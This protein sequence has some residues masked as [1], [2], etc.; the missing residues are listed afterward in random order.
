MKPFVLLGLLLAVP[1]CASTRPSGGAA[2]AP[3]LGGAPERP[4]DPSSRWAPPPAISL[5]PPPEGDYRLAPKDQV[6]VQVHG[7]D[8][9]TRTVRISEGGTVPL[10]LLG[11]VKVPV[12]G[13]TL[14]EAEAKIKAGLKGR[15]LVNPRV[16]VS[17]VEFAG[18][19]VAVMGAVQQPGAYALKGNATTVLVALAEARGVRENADRVAYVVRARPRVGEP[20]PVVVD[21]GALLRTGDGRYNVALEGGDA[22]FVPE[23]SVYYVA[24][25]VEKRGAYPLRRGMTVSKALAEAGGVTK[26]AATGEIKIVRTLPSG[27]RREITGIDLEAVMSG[28]QSQDPPLETHDVVMVPASGAKVVAHGVL[29]F[30]RG[31]LSLGITP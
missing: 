18:R 4:A 7:H 21:L 17:V 10:P 27:E 30:F 29:D 31:I 12:A 5:E 20:Q 9:L 1:G 26:R 2:L 13:L 22:V 15:Y 14:A 8:D 24:G 6:V 19:K 11:D 28:D 25:E 16:T 23:A 3:Q